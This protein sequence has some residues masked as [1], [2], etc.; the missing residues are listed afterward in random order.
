MGDTSAD[1]HGHK[2]N[3]AGNHH[4]NLN[5]LASILISLAR[6]PATVSINPG[7]RAFPTLQLPADFS[8]FRRFCATVHHIFNVPDSI[9][10][11]AVF[12]GKAALRKTVTL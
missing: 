8:G 4:S 10:G 6:G 12:V 9:S 5:R 2:A 3:P 1:A 7:N 11:V